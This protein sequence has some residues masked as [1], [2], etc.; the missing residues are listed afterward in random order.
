MTVQ[1]K[2]GRTTPIGEK[3]GTFLKLYIYHFPEHKINL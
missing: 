2:K 3:N 1:L